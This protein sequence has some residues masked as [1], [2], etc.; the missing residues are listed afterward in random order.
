LFS[1]FTVIEF[2]VFYREGEESIDVKEK[3]ESREETGHENGEH[4]VI[5]G[6][7]EA[8]EDVDFHVDTDTSEETIDTLNNMKNNGNAWRDSG[9]ITSGE[10]DFIIEQMDYNIEL[11]RA[12]CVCCPWL[13]A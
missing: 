2:N 8:V 5:A 9:Y 6:Y 12:E 10:E 4:Y 3:T 7:G 11:V 13:L 1:K